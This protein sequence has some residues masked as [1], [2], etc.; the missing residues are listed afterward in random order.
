[1]PGLLS[2]EES[3]LFRRKLKIMLMS[4]YMY[5]TCVRR[6]YKVKSHEGNTKEDYFHSMITR[7]YISI[8][9]SI[10]HQRF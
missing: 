3:V 10:S 9:I 2:K 4:V 5:L 6:H 7:V 8:T 1:M